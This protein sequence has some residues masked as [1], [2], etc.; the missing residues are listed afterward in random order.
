MIKKAIFY[1]F[2]AIIAVAVLWFYGTA[3][4][5]PRVVTVP[6]SQPSA[7]RGAEV[8]RRTTAV[9]ETGTASNSIPTKQTVVVSGAFAKEQEPV[10]FGRVETNQI[11]VAGQEF[12]VLF[13][14]SGVSGLLKRDILNDIELNL[15]HLDHIELRPLESDDPGQLFR[16]TVTHVLDEG[17]Q[18][19]LFPSVL[20]KYFGGAILSEGSYQIVI[21]EELI[22]AYER[23]VKYREDH[24]VMFRK[25]EVFLK[26]LRDMDFIAQIEHQKDTAER[27]I[28]FDVEPSLSYD[29]GRELSGLLKH[30]DIRRP[31]LL[32][33]NSVVYNG[34]N[35]VRFST[36]IGWPES[37]STEPFTKGFPQFIYLDEEWRVYVPKM[38]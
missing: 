27:F 19:R 32:D 30:G 18:E 26:Q 24:P 36:V 1:V 20:E 15:S 9:A 28:A 6:E 25:L 21:H 14:V 37:M 7:A 35:A 33:F 29:Y 23:A 4:K 31:S 34:E 5:S 8:L 22:N 3:R 10:E 38:L 17:R 13:E 11:R 2:G 16:V 12:T